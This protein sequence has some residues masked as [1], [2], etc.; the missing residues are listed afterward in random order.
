MNKNIPF[1]DL[2]AQ[3][4][5]ISNEINTAISNVINE[6]AFIQSKYVREFE[7]NFSFFCG[8]KYCIGVGNGTD[9]LFIALKALNIKAGDEV[10]VPSNT[11]IATSEAVSMT[12]AK[13]VFIDCDPIS[14]NIDVNL[15][16]S[17]ITNKTKA[18][19]PVHLYGQ[20]AEMEN[21]STIAK[22]YNIKIIQDCA[23][24]HGAT[25]NEKKLAFFGD[26]LCFSF[27]PGKNLG[28]YG[29]AGAVVTDDKSLADKC[30]MFANHGRMS[31]FNH[32]FEGINSR[33]DGIQAAVLDVK[34]KYLSKWNDQRRKA[35]FLYNDL[36]K[37]LNQI[38]IPDIPLNKKHVFHLYVIR[39]KNRKE[40]QSF[41]KEKG[42]S[43]SIHYPI[44]L[45]YLKA[46]EYLKH[47]PEDFPVSNR[48]QE[49][50]LSLPIFPELSKEN[51]T[52]ISQSI[53]TFFQ[54][55]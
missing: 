4:K 37:D 53:H 41:L 30:R 26:I 8:A 42:I 49:E 50:I 16:E 35:A 27:Y 39:T 15:I 18:I 52:Y 54:N 51:I 33:L 24:A 7:K 13:I 55:I 31:K 40:L 2:N 3:Y 46:Y 44:A 6:T 1:V 36:L 14:Y 45:P 25:I 34:L 38:T 10:I 32:E 21:I 47:I 20:P 23:Q 19:I 48:Y 29:D 22:K 5:K 17:K 11:F 9:A 43:T 28:A 12:G